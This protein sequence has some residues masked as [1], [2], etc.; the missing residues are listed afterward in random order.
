MPR[1]PAYLRLF[2]R[3]TDFA[4]T[5]D[6]IGIKPDRNVVLVFLFK[7]VIG[8]DLKLYFINL[9]TRFLLRF[10]DGCLFWRFAKIDMTTVWNPRTIT[11]RGM[12]LLF[13]LYAVTLL[14]KD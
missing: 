6:I 3:G 12:L 9:H 2:L 8:N 10:A 11:M 4:F 14:N 1:K 7:Y 5:G 13:L